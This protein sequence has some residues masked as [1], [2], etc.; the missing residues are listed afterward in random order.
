[1]RLRVAFLI[2]ACFFTSSAFSQE[3]DELQLRLRVFE[4][5]QNICKATVLS[6]NEAAL[7]FIRSG[8][9]SL[10]DRCECAALLAVSKRSET[11]LR[12]M[13]SSADNGPAIEFAADV[14]SS[15]LQCVRIN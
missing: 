15:F 14:R 13:L 6:N 5:A 2:T 1:M 7:S 9:G 10:S 4:N 8:S 12:S 3:L 11:D